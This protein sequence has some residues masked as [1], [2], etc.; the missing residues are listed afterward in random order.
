[1]DH[2]EH[3]KNALQQLYQNIVIDNELIDSYVFTQE[4][5]NVEFVSPNYIVFDIKTV[6]IKIVYDND[7][8]ILITPT[9]TLIINQYSNILTIGSQ[10]GKNFDNFNIQINDYLLSI[11]N[12]HYTITCADVI[13]NI[14]N[15]LKCNIQ[16]ADNKIKHLAQYV[17]IT[18]GDLQYKWK[19]KLHSDKCKLHVSALYQNVVYIKHYMIYQL[20]KYLWYKSKIEKYTILFKNK[21]YIIVYFDD[22]KI[23]KFSYNQQLDCFLY[24][25]ITIKN[26]NHVINNLLL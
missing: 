1:M 4:Q 8:Y 2:I 12:N 13:I 26:I 22:L 3:A 9:F 21:K 19:Y 14:T 17:K 25:D 24:Q 11:K 5:Y 20:N 23:I 7:K 16:C 10:E 15:I 6:Q 18:K